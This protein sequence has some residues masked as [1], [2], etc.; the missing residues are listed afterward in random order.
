VPTSA[1]PEN[2]LKTAVSF[3]ILRE[4]NRLASQLSGSRAIAAKWSSAAH[5]TCRPSIAENFAD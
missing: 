2:I 3:P 4:I 1:L 5:E